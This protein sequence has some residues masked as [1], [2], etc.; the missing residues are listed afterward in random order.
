MNIRKVKK[1]DF[2]SILDLQLQL[3]DAE[4]EYDSNLVKHCYA[5]EEGKKRLKK[6]I[7]KRSNIFFVAVNDDNNVIGFVDGYI[8]EDEWWY[9]EPVA[10]LDHIVVDKK[11]RKKGVASK[12]IEKFEEIVKENNVKRIKLNAFPDNTPAINLY[13]KF[14]FK[15]YSSYYDKIIK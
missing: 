13:T 6:R 8:P 11:Y 5:T 12:L 10:Y 3:E 4:Y 7:S 14:G 9:K 15:C 2:D 1:T